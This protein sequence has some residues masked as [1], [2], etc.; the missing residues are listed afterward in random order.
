MEWG[1]A[2]LRDAPQKISC[3]SGSYDCS[4]VA[5]N[6]DQLVE[7]LDLQTVV[8]GKPEPVR[9]VEQRKRTEHEQI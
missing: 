6:V 7:M 8:K 2:S 9:P 5:E 4:A 1:R 3:H